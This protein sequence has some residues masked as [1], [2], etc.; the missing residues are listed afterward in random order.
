MDTQTNVDL[1]MQAD[2]KDWHHYEIENKRRE[3]LA[4]LEK[5]KE[6]EEKPELLKQKINEDI[7]RRLIEGK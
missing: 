7:T 5:V 1:L 6:L 2:L 4:R 3:L